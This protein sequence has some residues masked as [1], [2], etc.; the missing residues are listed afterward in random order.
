MT[1]FAL[2]A[3]TLLLL[4][5][6]YV[7]R[8]L[9]WPGI[10]GR[11][12]LASAEI[13]LAVLREHR[14]ELDQERQ[15]GSL[16]GA[17]YEQACEELERRVLEDAGGRPAAVAPGRRQ[18]RLALLL[19]LVLPLAVVATYVHLGSPEVF[20][21]GTAREDGAAGA[22]ALTQ[23][24]ILSMVEG[25]AEKLQANPSDGGG[26]LMLARSYAVLG[27]F[28]E[29]AAAYGRA[30]ALLPPDAQTLADFADTVAMAQGRRLQGEPEKL[31]RQALAV[32]PRNLKALALAGTLAF[33]RRDYAAAI[34][35]WQQVLALVPAD[36]NVARN[37]Q[38]SI[39]DAEQ[40]AGG[41]P[42]T[43]RP[44]AG[45]APGADSAISG[46]VT[47]DPSLQ[48]KVAPGDTVFIFARAAQGPKM[49]LAILR[50]TAAELPLRFALDDSLA[51]APDLRL[52]RQSR[53][54][55]GAR[56]SRH[57]SALPQPG[58]LQGLSAVLA[59]GSKDV[60][61]VIDTVIDPP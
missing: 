60:K 17:A 34:G 30:T 2:V 9:L 25:L 1:A 45:A 6:T 59:P 31:V 51:L 11:P 19:V 20:G 16:S 53:V 23:Q 46:R 13:S 27:R 15:R 57:G 14:A 21:A 48:G 47:L 43:D 49:P 24:E 29:A 8:P 56:I 35:Q 52:S 44:A 7:L 26:W 4:V 36:S 38:G 22:H 54:V 5:L 40:R 41:R 33:E 58:D 18:P 37:I 3:G 55:V 39:R 10:K 12:G 28:P 61:I 42:G 50:K 32:D